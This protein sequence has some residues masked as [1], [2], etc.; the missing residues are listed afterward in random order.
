M[1]EISSSRNDSCPRFSFLMITYNQEK[2]IADALNSALAQDYPNLE[3]VVSDDCSGDRTFII[4]T[5][6]ARD[7]HGPHKIILNRN[8]PNLGIGGNFHKAYTLASGEWLFMAAGDD[9]SLPNRCRV[10][11]D[12]IPK[13]PAALVFGTNNR[14][15]DGDNALYGYYYIPSPLHLGAALAWHRR[16]F[17][18]FP[19]LD[20]ANK[21]EDFPLLARV[22]CLNGQLVM[23][24]DLAMHYRIDGH[25]FTGIARDTAYKVKLYKRRVC[26]TMIYSVQHR[27]KDLDYAVAHWQVNYAD[28][29]RARFGWMLRSLQLE[30]DSHDFA[31]QVIEGSYW[32]RLRYIITPSSRPLHQSCLGR[33]RLVLSS[34]PLMIFIKRRLF[35][36]KP[37]FM[38]RLLDEPSPDKRDVAVITTEYYLDNPNCDFYISEYPETFY[39]DNN[40]RLNSTN[41]ASM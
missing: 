11:A 13:Y 26:D 7:Y 22:F 37:R 30:R 3:I 23:L 17:T 33:L 5:E 2:Y 24:P 25:S 18:E 40:G 8:E 20:P 35:K 16:V 28:N 14:I 10:V 41:S 19:P 21:T 29:L 1:P 39:Q 9:I 34:I 4:A 38:P 31:V 15:I 27:I 36:L 12:A 6:I 32:Q